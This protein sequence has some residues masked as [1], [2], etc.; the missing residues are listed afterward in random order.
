VTIRE[1]QVDGQTVWTET[2]VGRALLKSAPA[3]VTRTGG[4][5]RIVG[6]AWGGPIAPGPRRHD[7]PDRVYGGVGTPGREPIPGID[8]ISEVARR[9]QVDDGGIDALVAEKSL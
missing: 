3:K 4:Q 1:Q 6:A 2:S 9:T 8:C 5:Y 7:H